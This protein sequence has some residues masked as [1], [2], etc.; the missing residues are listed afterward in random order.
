MMCERCEADTAEFEQLWGRA[1]AA[2]AARARAQ[3]VRRVSFLI[4]AEDEAEVVEK[5]IAL[6]HPIGHLTVERIEE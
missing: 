5:L 4:P 1:N 3:S 2:L 6:P